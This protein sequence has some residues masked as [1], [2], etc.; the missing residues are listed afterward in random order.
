MC[1]MDQNDAMG[2]WYDSFRASFPQATHRTA[3]LTTPQLT[4][5]LPLLRHKTSERFGTSN[6]S[7]EYFQVLFIVSYVLLM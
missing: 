6:Q 3:L 7:P 4:S 5:P 1:L 2:V